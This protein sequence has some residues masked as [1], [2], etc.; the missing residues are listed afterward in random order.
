ME[1]GG[2]YYDNGN[3][4]TYKEILFCHIITS[5]SVEYSSK[6]SCI[7]HKQLEPCLLLVPIDAHTF[8][9]YNL[10]SLPYPYH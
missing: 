2:Y 1:R 7:L 3:N 5:F 6:D 4:N 10:E 8:H 9:T